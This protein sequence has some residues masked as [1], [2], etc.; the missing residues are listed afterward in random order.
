MKCITG[1]G[2]RGVSGKKD[3]GMK[4]GNYLG[5][6][7]PCAFCRILATKFIREEKGDKVLH[8]CDWH[9]A[10]MKRVFKELKYNGG[11][12]K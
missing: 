12:R 1:E 9:F 6:D 8:L 7:V 10:E 4:A 3:D 2:K 11:N 5:A